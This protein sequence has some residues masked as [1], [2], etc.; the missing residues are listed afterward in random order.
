MTIQEQNHK[1]GV[2][3]MAKITKPLSST[4]VQQA[5]S[6]DKDYTYLDGE[7][8]QFRSIPGFNIS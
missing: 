3:K 7:K 6:S 4:E 8:L 5:K 2:V 1:Y